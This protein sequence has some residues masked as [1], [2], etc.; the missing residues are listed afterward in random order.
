MVQPLEVL[1]TTYKRI[2]V[3]DSAVNAI[4]YGVWCRGRAMF[5]RAC[6]RVCARTRARVG[7]GMHMRVLEWAA[8]FFGQ[9]IPDGA[10]AAQAPSS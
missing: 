7:M 3:K 2:V 10:V 8:H 1:L 4:C 5:V 9:Q 6:V